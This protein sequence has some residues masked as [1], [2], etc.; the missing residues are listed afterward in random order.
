MSVSKNH[1]M[2][3]V[4]RSSSFNLPVM[5]RNTFQ[6]YEVAESSIQAGL[7][8]LQEWG[9]PSLSGQPVPFYHLHSKG[10]PINFAFLIDEYPS[11]GGP[12]SI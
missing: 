2:V 4:G 3:W 7:E 5:N 9:I 12:M 8:Y 6:F 1:G 11:L 10:L